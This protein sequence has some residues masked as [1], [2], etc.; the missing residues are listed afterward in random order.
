LYREGR[1]C[2]EVSLKRLHLKL[3]ETLMSLYWKKSSQNL[4]SESDKINC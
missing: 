4:P 1:N 2:S 3:H